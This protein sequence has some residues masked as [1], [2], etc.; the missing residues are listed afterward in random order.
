MRRQSFSDMEYAP[1]EENQA[2]GI[3]GNYGGSYSVGGMGRSGSSQLSQWETWPS[4]AWCG[5]HV[6]DVSVSKLI[7]SVRRGSGRR[8][9]RQLRIPKTHES[10]FSWGRTSA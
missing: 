10:G 3:S 1:E 4:A 5:N 6:E 9:I 2:G 8:H 7:Q